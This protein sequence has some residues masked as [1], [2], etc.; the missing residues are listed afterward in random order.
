MNYSCNKDYCNLTCVCDWGIIYTTHHGKI[1][2]YMDDNK[3]LS[4]NLIMQKDTPST[5]KHTTYNAPVPNP[6]M[7]RFVTE[8][9]ACVVHISVVKW[10]IVGWYLLMYCGIC[11]TVFSHRARL[12]QNTYS[13][14]SITNNIT[15]P[16]APKSWYLCSAETTYNKLMNNLSE[17]PSYPAYF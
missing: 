2:F 16:T 5:D 13:T 17:L 3:M 15:P 7:Y 10:G 8:M 14:L 1:H 4:D 11:A 12:K 9:C 6:T